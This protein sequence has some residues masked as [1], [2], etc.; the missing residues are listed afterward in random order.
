[1]S[2]SGRLQ[3]FFITRGDVTRPG[4]NGMTMRYKKNVG[5]L[6]EDFAAQMLENSGF[7]ILERNYR[8]KAGEIDIIASKNGVIHFVEV[9]TRTKYYGKSIYGS[10]ASAVDKTK[11]NHIISAARAYL[12]ENYHR[13]LPRFDVIEV[14]V[15]HN[16]N[17]FK[18]INVN[19]LPRAFASGR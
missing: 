8:T 14:Y 4:R 10:A 17:L 15:E 16:D 6:G 11:Q 5:D 19:H 13:R 1:M 2:Q 7:M 3:A 18:V 12:K 9:K